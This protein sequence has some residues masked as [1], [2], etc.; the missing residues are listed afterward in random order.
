M[1]L[2]VALL[3]TVVAGSAAAAV[4]ALRKPASPRPTERPIRATPIGTGDALV[5]EAGRGEA[6][7]LRRGL[8]VSE[9][10]AEA[11]LHLFE[12]DT[13]GGVPRV[14]AWESTRPTR[15][16]LLRTDEHLAAV[17]V[18]QPSSLAF[19]LE[20][21]EVRVRARLRRT[22]TLVADGPGVLVDGAREIVIL[23][24][25]DDV[26]VVLL[27]TGGDACALVGRTRAL[28]SISVLASEATRQDD[29][30]RSA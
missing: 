23:E 14:V 2:E 4:R 1:I 29:S 21:L 17:S 19:D 9:G 27:G 16:A 10:S 20:G 11:F 26:L 8:E 24:G 15:V 12:A 25:D 3:V 22:A 30:D 5:L 6:W 13:D 7:S 18:H 28:A